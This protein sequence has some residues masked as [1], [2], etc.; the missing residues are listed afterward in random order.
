M[1]GAQNGFLT[2][3]RDSSGNVLPMAAI[4]ML[5]SAA[6]VGGGVDMSRAYRVQNR[7]QSACDAGALAGRRAVTT[8][9]FD[10]VYAKPQAAAYFTTNFDDTTMETTN[11][12]FTPTS[13]D[14]GQTVN[15]TASTELKLAVMKI[16]GFQK[17]ALSV[18][19]TASM[20]VGNS[21]VMMVLDTTGSMDWAL[22]SS[23][24][25]VELRI[26]MKNFYTTVKN[27]TTGT[28]ARIR[29]GFVPFSST[30]NVGKLLYAKN[31][32]YLVDTYHIQSRYP[33]TKDKTSTMTTA[34]IKNLVTTTPVKQTADSWDKQSKCTNNL[35]KDV[36]TNTGDPE[37][38]T[39]TVTVGSVTTVVTTT[40]QAQ[41]SSKIYS[42]QK[43]G[44]KY[45]IYKA[46]GTRDSYTYTTTETDTSV[47]VF[48]YFTYKQRTETAANPLPYASYKA[49][50]SVSLPM[51]GDG[52][53]TLTSTWAGCIEER[54][55]VSESSFSYSTTSGITP[56]GS[57]DLDID[58]AP[59]SAPETKWAPMWP[60]IAY[61]RRTSSGGSLTTDATSLYGSKANSYCPYTAKH[62]AEMTQSEF[63]AYADALSPAG[64]T[65]LDIGMVWGGRLSSPQGIFADNVNVDP[66]NG[67]EVS[68]HLSFMSDGD[69]VPNH[70][71]QSAW[72]IAWHDR[73]VS[74]DRTDSQYKARH[75][76]RFQAICEAIKA[77]GIRVWTI[78]F[79]TGTSSVLSSCASA[80]SYYNA[81]D[82]AELNAAFQEI[83]KQVGE[84]RLTQ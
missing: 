15:A 74:A 10:T 69:M 68:R 73:P 66:A 52:G 58:T 37:V 29:Y 8:N 81:D 84:L 3:L 46:S 51:M 21:D 19:C 39:S 16:F 44:S 18:T 22:G 13:P 31:P 41:S 30:V 32:D 62:F 80:N 82:S 11:T 55:T 54:G 20:G 26:A 14:N 42:C 71:S 9:G 4:G 49:G 57:N 67:G 43:D 75:I 6:L 36:W 38:T 53:T 72:C 50:G 28:N 79:T 63:N 64:S 76:S 60:E 7:L 5:L 1:T 27:A 23:T 35:P 17:F 2:V 25:I 24:R 65:Y 47:K 48:D 59:T 61:Y 83:A 34:E 33:E 78:S 40:K 70:T 77:K 45:Y 56:T 12:V